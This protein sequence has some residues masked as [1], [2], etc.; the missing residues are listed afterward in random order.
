[1][2][3]S[4][5]KADEMLRIRNESFMTADI[6]AYAS[7]WNED[8]VIEMGAHQ[9]VGEAA[10]RKAVSGAWSVSRVLHFE[11]RSF[12][13]RGNQILNEFAIVWQDKK[14]GETRLETGMGVLEVAANGRWCSLRDYMESS[15]GVRASAAGLPAIRGLIEPMR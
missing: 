14:S 11:T 6:E 8:G 9:F 10:I 4:E 7:L 12:A 1:M 2:P 13:V 5:A 3:V 15:D